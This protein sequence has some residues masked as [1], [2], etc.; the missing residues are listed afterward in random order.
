MPLVGGR[1]LPGVAVDPESRVGDYWRA[2]LEQ[3]VDGDT[4]AGVPLIKLPEDLRVYEHLLWAQRPDCVIEIGVALGASALWFRDRLRTLATY[5]GSPLPR[6]VGIDID[7][8][9]AR[10]HLQRADPHYAEQIVL[11][12]ADVRDPDLPA[13]VRREI[14][15]GTCLVIEDGAHTYETTL[16]ALEGFAS[17]VAA[18]G[19]FVVEDGVVDDDVLRLHDDWP[20]GVR[21]AIDDWLAGPAGAGFEQRREL[22]LYGITSHP[23]GFLQRRSAAPTTV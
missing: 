21:A 7:L 22:E 13:R 2:R 16:A 20:R 19:F 6:F 1:N 17:F 18:E 15:S 4:Y 5:G 11:V 8:G 14:G 23:G 9:P 10:E 12:E 3:A